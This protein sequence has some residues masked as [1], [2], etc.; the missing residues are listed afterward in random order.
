M[1]ALDPSVSE[2]ILPWGH[3]ASREAEP[4]FALLAELGVAW[5]VGDGGA[6]E[7]PR[8]VPLAYYSLEAG[9]DLAA[10]RLAAVD[11]EFR[12]ALCAVVELGWYSREQF[13]A[14]E[15]AMAFA[16]AEFERRGLAHHHALTGQWVFAEDAA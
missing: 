6:R 4:L 2:E 5:E 10:V 8:W 7:P 14:L 3:F 16:Q 11:E 9:W 13:Y 12:A 1:S 15:S